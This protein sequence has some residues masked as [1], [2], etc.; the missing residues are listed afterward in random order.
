MSATYNVHAFFCVNYSNFWIAI[1]SIWQIFPYAYILILYLHCRKWFYI[2]LMVCPWKSGT[3]LSPIGHVPEFVAARSL[4]WVFC[5]F[6]KRN[7]K[8]SRVDVVLCCKWSE[9]SV[10]RDCNL[11]F[12]AGGC[13]KSW[14]FFL[15]GSPRGL[16]LFSRCS[17]SK[18]WYSYTP[19]SSAQRTDLASSSSM[20]SQVLRCINSCISE[21]ILAR[22]VGLM[23]ETLLSHCSQVSL[24]VTTNFH[25]NLWCALFCS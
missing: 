10:L 13:P 7:V 11:D 8:S 23:H 24:P 6:N 1:V 17:S 19:S 18:A 4:L 20:M 16:L 14:S 25:F 22:V 12:L 3:Q 5:T 2:R 21:W 9:Q 15:I